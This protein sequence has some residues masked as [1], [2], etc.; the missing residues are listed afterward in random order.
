MTP[1][2]GLLQILGIGLVV[3]L[4]GLVFFTAWLL[5]HPPRRTYA[6]ALARRQPGD[7]GE[8]DDSLAFEEFAVDTSHGAFPIW[9]ITGRDP[10]G[11]VVFMSH[12]WGSSR[13]GALKRMPPIVERASRLIAWDMPGHGEAPMNARLGADEHEIAAEILN[14]LGV[15]EQPLVLYGWSMGAGVSLALCEKVQSSYDVR[16]VICESIYRMPLTP[17]RAVL[18]LRGMPHRLSLKPAIALLGLKYGVGMK[19]RGFDRAEIASRLTAPIL[20]LH[21]DHDP[22]SPLG[23]ALAVDRAAPVAATSKIEGAGHN[24]IWTD[25]VFREVAIDAVGSF[26]KEGL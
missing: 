9:D 5:T 3:A 25:P 17:A 21:G 1:I 2:L 18:L 8:L 12:G 7:P 11:P 23:D 20:L 14:E 19:W 13:V 10:M 15:N 24:N 16:G 22:V 26:L 6:W 4:G